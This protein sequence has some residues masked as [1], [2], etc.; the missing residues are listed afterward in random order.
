MLTV[1]LYVY[2]L[3]TVGSTSYNVN[4]LLSEFIVRDKTLKENLRLR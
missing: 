3:I 4:T 1:L 2:K